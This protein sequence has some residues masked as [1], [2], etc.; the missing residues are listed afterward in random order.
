MKGTWEGMKNAL[1]KKV[2]NFSGNVFVR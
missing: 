2:K 1:K